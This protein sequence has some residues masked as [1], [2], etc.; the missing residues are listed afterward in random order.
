MTLYKKY[1]KLLNYIQRKT[2]TKL[3]KDCIQNGKHKNQKDK[4]VERIMLLKK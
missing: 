4:L 3:Y 1:L 2:K